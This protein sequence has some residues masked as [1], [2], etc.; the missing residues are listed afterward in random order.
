MINF[1]VPAPFCFSGLLVRLLPNLMTLCREG[2]SMKS[3]FQNVGGPMRR[4]ASLIQK[5]MLMSATTSI[6]MIFNEIFLFLPTGA[7]ILIDNVIITG[8][9]CATRCEQD[10][11]PGKSGHVAGAK[12]VQRQ[13]TGSQRPNPGTQQI[14]KRKD[15]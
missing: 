1:E 8:T 6:P 5:I 10:P 9:S 11:A 13:N 14:D 12:G 15:F 3:S 4:Y 2:R 7:N